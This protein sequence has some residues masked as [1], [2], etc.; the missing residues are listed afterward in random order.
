MEPYGSRST[1]QRQL[2]M[3]HATI[4]SIEVDEVDL[5]QIHSGPFI[6]ADTSSWSVS[7]AGP[8]RVAT[9]GAQRTLHFTVA[10][11]S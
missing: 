10:R 1:E 5:V 8:S 7:N 6:R 4:E 9:H 2:V 11:K 3:R